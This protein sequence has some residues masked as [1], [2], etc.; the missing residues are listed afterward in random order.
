MSE[1]EVLQVQPARLAGASTRMGAG[2][3]LATGAPAL[4][5]RIIQAGSVR[6]LISGNAMFLPSAR[7]T[8]M[9]RVWHMQ[10]MK[11]IQL[12]KKQELHTTENIVC[13]F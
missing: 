13:L 8:L 2:F 11:Q 1:V 6:F 10:K 4:D 9:M 7:I 12:K 3:F 5:I